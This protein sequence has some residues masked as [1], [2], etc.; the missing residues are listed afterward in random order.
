[1]VPRLTSALSGARLRGRGRSRPGEALPPRV[2]PRGATAPRSIDCEAGFEAAL[3][4]YF[5]EDAKRDGLA[6][7]GKP[8][9]SV[10]TPKLPMSRFTARFPGETFEGFVY[11][12]PTMTEGEEEP[13][14]DED[15][16]KDRVCS[17]SFV[18]SH[19]TSEEKRQLEQGW[20][21]TIARLYLEGKVKRSDGR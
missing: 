7:Q 20:N 10:A 18:D 16:Q 4:H 2:P 8:T 21:G 1:M 6:V 14:E 15:N 5:A 3:H 9:L 12:D 11:V 17:A 13:W 19:A